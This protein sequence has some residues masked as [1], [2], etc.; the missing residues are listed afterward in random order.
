MKIL[1][2]YVP[3]MDEG[4]GLNLLHS[5]PE[6]FEVYSDTAEALTLR[7]AGDFVGLVYAPYADVEIRA[8]SSGYFRGVAWADSL[9]VRV[10]DG[11]GIGLD[12]GLQRYQ[13]FSN[14]AYRVVTE[15]WREGEP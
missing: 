8:G 3:R 4:A 6:R 7:S 2:T 14:Y 1:A 11:G 15:D 13:S 9:T 5:D 10:S 12:S